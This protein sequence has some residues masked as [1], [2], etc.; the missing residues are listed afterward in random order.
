M[1]CPC[2][3]AVERRRLVSIAFRKARELKSSIEFTLPRVI[4][5]DRLAGNENIPFEV[6]WNRVLALD[7]LPQTIRSLHCPYCCPPILSPPGTYT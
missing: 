7:P 6:A 2:K 1:Y 3:D 4:I 5:A